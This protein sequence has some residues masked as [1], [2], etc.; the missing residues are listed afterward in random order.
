MKE[1]LFFWASPDFALRARL[2]APKDAFGP[3][4]TLVGEGAKPRPRGAGAA[5]RNADAELA[6]RFNAAMQRGDTVHQREQAR[7]ELHVRGDA[8]TALALAQKNW[9]V[10]KESA[11]MRVL[12]EAALMSGNKAAAAP[13]LE[14]ASRN[15][16]ED[17]A[18]A[19]L[20][21]QLKAGA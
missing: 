9:D 15:S 14:W 2:L 3:V 11:D 20:A 19:R 5:L 4:V 6:A 18:V 12:L 1:T 21:K 16:V 13:A 7:Y 17:V 10:Q 8:K